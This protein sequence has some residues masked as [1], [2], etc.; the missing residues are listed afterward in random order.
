MIE[1]FVSEVLDTRAQK[2]VGTYKGTLL[3]CAGARS[4]WDDLKAFAEKFHGKPDVMAVNDFGMF[5]PSHLE[6]WFSLHGEQLPG[7]C[8]VREFHHTPVMHRHT[9]KTQRH[10]I[11][12]AVP[13]MGTSS[14]SGVYV[15]LALGYDRIVLCGAPLND[16][17]HFFDPPWV[18][19]NFSNEGAHDIWQRAN[20]DIFEGRVSSMSG[21]SREI[22]GAP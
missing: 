12:W 18:A 5:Y 19:T 15:G 1:K 4:V 11:P 20:R 10:G 3:I 21:V 22:L 14:L 9:T 7:W 13:M 16:E 6:H 8:A 2:L 17:A